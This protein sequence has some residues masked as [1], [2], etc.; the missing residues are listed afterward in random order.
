MKN[1]FMFW[2]NTQDLDFSLMFSKINPLVTV[3]TFLQR[4]YTTIISIDMMTIT[5]TVT[6]VLVLPACS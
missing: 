1:R 3:R 4:Q 6:T 5:I 2:S